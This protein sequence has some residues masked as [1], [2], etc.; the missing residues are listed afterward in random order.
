MTLYIAHTREMGVYCSSL[1]GSLYF[2]T[3][4]MNDALQP[5]EIDFTYNLLL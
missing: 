5:F 4:A 2:C 3:R 1:E